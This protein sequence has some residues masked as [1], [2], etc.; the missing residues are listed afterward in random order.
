[1]S[2]VIK[3]VLLKKKKKK[4]VDELHQQNLLLD[5]LSGTIVEEVETFA[6]IQMLVKSGMASKFFNIGDQI[7]VS[8]T[9]SYSGITYQ[10]PFDIVH[11]GHVT[12]QSGTNK[13]PA[14]YLQWHYTTPRQIMFNTD[15]NEG[16]ILWSESYIREW[17]NSDT[18]MSGF[19]N[20]FLSILCPTEVITSGGNT[21]DTFYL[22][23]LNNMNISCSNASTEYPQDLI[24]TYK[25]EGEVFDYWKDL[26]NDTLMKIFEFDTN[27]GE[28]KFFEIGSQGSKRIL[29]R[30][31]ISKYNQYDQIWHINIDGGANS[32]YPYYTSMDWRCTPICVIC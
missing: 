5:I 20:D 7:V 17:L 19:E 32:Q 14:M 29:L 24:D 8:W 10:V 16:N 27:Y 9:D 23:S 18:F 31:S 13:V 30:S 12:T 11:F 28:L 1:M 4:I 26:S 2:K 21:F 25:T 3:P 6:D 15:D 22:P